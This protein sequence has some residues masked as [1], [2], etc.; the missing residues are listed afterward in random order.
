M[1]DNSEFIPGDKK[2]SNGYSETSVS[3][4]GTAST[5]PSTP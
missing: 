1:P 2:L 4:D 5:K 3:S